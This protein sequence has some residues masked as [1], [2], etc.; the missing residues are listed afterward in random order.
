IARSLRYSVN[1]NNGHLF[2][3]MPFQELSDEDLTAIVSFL[4]SQEPVTHKVEPSEYTFLGK[5]LMAFGLMKPQG[6]TNTPPK[7]VEIDSTIAY[8]SYLANRVANC[9]GCHTKRDFMTGAFIGEPLAGG[10][11]F[12]PDVFSQGYSFVTPNLTPH[13]ETGIIATWDESTFITRMR[14]GRVHNGTPMPWAIFGRMTDL[15]LKAI[16]RYLQSLDPVDNKIDKIV[17]AP[18]EKFME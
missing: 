16:Y 5:A 8:G 1:R 18:G 6:P 14:G 13:Q 15:E 3:F 9:N 12:L 10:T 4:R 2:P 11:Q 17:Y 7:S